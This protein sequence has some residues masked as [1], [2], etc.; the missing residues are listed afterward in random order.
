M[1]AS[2]LVYEWRTDGGRRVHS[3]AT[4]AD[5]ILNTNRMFELK[6]TSHGITGGSGS[7]AC[8]WFFDNPADWRDGGAYMRVNRTVTQLITQSGHSI[9]YNSITLDVF[10][11]DDMTAD[12]EEVT[13]S[14]I[15]VAYAWAHDSGDACY[16]VYA[17]GA[18]GMRRVLC[19][20]TLVNLYVELLD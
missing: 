2:A 11:D 16:V 8:L 5:Y 10:P 1:F 17:D 4:T 14:K 13:I 12:T 6:A 18:W 15:A 20:I 19:D 9:T 7:Q 3:R